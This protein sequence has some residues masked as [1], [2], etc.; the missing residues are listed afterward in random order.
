MFKV[1]KIN[2]LLL[3]LLIIA[4]VD[5]FVEQDFTSAKSNDEQKDII[6][7]ETGY[8]H[9]G[10]IVNNDNDEYGDE[11]WMWGYNQDGELGNIT[12]KEQY[13]N[14][15]IKVEG[16]PE[17]NIINLE[18]NEAS[19]GVSI[20]IDGDGIADEVWVWG[21]DWS[22]QSSEGVGEIP[23][24]L[25]LNSGDILEFEMSKYLNGGV[26]LD[27]NKDGFGDQIW[28]WGNNL[29]GELGVGFNSSSFH[30]IQTKNTWLRG[31]P[32]DLELGYK[33]SAVTI[34]TN[35]DKKG[36]ELW[37]WGDNEYGQLGV[38]TEKP[39][40]NVAIKVEGLPEGNDVDYDYLNLGLIGE[41][42]IVINNELWMWGNNDYG[43]MGVETI[44]ID[45]KTPTKIPNL[46]KGTITNFELG[47]GFASIVIDNE[48]WT[49]GN[50]Q[51]GQL[52]D[53]THEN[54][55][56]PQKVN[57][58]YDGD[59]EIISSGRNVAGVVINSSNWS[60]DDTL[61]M[62]GH[63]Q[64]GQLGDGTNNSSST[65]VEVS[66]KDIPSI[67]SENWLT[68]STWGKVT[69]SFIIILI[70][71]ILII[72]AFLIYKMFKNNKKI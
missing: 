41:T 25:D 5:S 27:I 29:D 33:N 36:D 9:S 59:I 50:N 54:N 37:M 61:L 48:L 60:S 22:D 2:V 53:G 66:L 69:L 15:P 40:S 64:Y 7:F 17:G 34:D 72:I 13:S 31:N 26:I 38:E 63:N 71:L 57:N 47:N 6:D 65:P 30:L 24:K 44:N 42:G 32:I 11:V 43:Q 8:Y 19:S 16:L 20:D 68:E 23:M 21:S 55:Y 12:S 45:Q 3:G 49:W 56:I 46:P 4:P 58:L 39:Y 51:I 70:L 14:T 1:K 18:I 67:P 62:W 10:I 52:G 35:G 28:M